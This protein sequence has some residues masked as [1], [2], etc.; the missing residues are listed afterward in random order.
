MADGL[1]HTCFGCHKPIADHEPHIHVNLDDWA[2]RNGLEPVGLAA[3]GL[4]DELTLAFCP[5]YYE[6]TP[7][8]GWCPEAHEVEIDDADLYRW[9]A[10]T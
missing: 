10:G 6:E 5:D 2:V 9:L 8:D 4:S 1:S 7:T 3:M